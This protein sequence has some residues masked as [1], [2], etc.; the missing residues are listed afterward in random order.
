MRPCLLFVCLV[1]LLVSGCRQSA[2]PR[3]VVVYVSVDQIH[4]EPVLKRFEQQ[5]GI[6]V[7]AVYDV[8]AA[9]TTG[10]ANRIVAERSRPQADLFWNGEF[11]Q[12]LRLQAEGL[13]APSSPASA[14][15]LPALMRD[16]QGM[17]FAS[18]GR[19]RA[20]LVNTAKLQPANRPSRIEDFLSPRWHGGDLAIAL[21]LF[22]TSAAQAAALYAT[23]GEQKAHDFYRDLSKRG[24]RVVDGNSVVRDLVAQGSAVAGFADS[25]DSCEA[26]ASGA[27]VQLVLPD[28]DGPGTLLV[29]GTVAKL[30]GSPHPREADALIDFLLAPETEKM[31]IDSGFFQVSARPGGAVSPCLQGR[32]VKTMQVGLPQIAAELER[33]RLDL[34][35]IFNR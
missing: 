30:A 7:R 17:W 11:V 20:I 2:P 12:T 1:L 14:A 9:K 13:L 8:E 16:P 21:P 6:A 28:Q 31:L 5:T 32:T 4:A 24:V 23:L 27:P 34:T 15:S 29:P 3:E 18:G 25:D 35:A 19:F 22:G 33:S 26:I 10:L